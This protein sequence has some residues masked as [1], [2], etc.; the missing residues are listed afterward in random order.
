MHQSCVL[1]FRQDLRLS[2]NPALRA[3][4]ADFARIV[5]LFIWSPQEEGRWPAGAASR[6]WLHHSLM[7]LAQAL[8]QR[9][10][11]LILRTGPAL[12]ALRSVL[13]ETGATAVYF[14]HR[15]E[16]EAIRVEREVATQL[17]AEGAIVKAFHSSLVFDPEAITTRA[18]R[19]FQV[20]TPFWR[21]C[22]TLPEPAAP[23]HAPKRIPGPKIWP[24][25]ARIHDLNLLPRTD[26]TAGFCKAW[27]PGEKNALLRLKTF[28]RGNLARYETQRDMPALDTTS[29][30]SPH[31]HF[32]EVSPR[33]VWHAAATAD[34]KAASA[35]LRQLAWR[36]FAHHLLIHFPRTPLEPLHAK[37]AKFRWRKNKLALKAWQ[38]GQTGYPLVDAGLRQLW[39]TGWMHNR[40]RMVV[41]SFLVKDL[42]LPWQE[43]ARW[44]WD[45]LVD[46]DL[47]NNTLGWQ[48]SAGC[49]AD[50]APFFRILNP[51]LQSERFDPRGTYIRQWIPEL[52]R[53]SAAHIH[54]PWQAPAEV[55]HAAGVRLGTNYPR[56]IVDHS[57]ARDQALAAF[58]QLPRG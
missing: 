14:S 16:P 7:S 49:G 52:R 23:L 53:L 33:Q 21:R 32:G 45:T 27:K 25:S 10:A 48:W 24:R 56:P 11:R 55:L 8:R 28:C 26:W 51:V 31:L 9:G 30:L 47:A 3:A 18:G 58:R 15:Y 20:F 50:A 54:A 22:M 57:A 37:Y 35:F 44:F 6:W 38:R 42:L 34:S 46:A 41:A 13:R 5:P 1:W 19:P 29:R 12:D 17:S 4:R 40:V 36:E 43:G 2:D 39:R